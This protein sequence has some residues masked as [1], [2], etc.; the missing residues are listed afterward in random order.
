MVTFKDLVEIIHKFGLIANASRI[1]Y[2]GIHFNQEDLVDL[3]DFI[4]SLF[5]E[6]PQLNITIH[7]QR[8][9]IEIQGNYLQYVI[10][11]VKELLDK[12]KSANFPLYWAQ[13]IE[14]VQTGI[15]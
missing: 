1:S 9:E 7:Q 5:V 4:L 14:S 11:K 12:I 8:E 10:H 3:E 2:K 6:S 15:I 13:K